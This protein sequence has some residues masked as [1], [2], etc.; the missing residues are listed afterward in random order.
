MELM[1]L[2]LARIL[3]VTLSAF[4]F[5]IVGAWATADQVSRVAYWVRRIQASMLVVGFVAIMAWA[6]Y[7]LIAGGP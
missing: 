1:D 7:S 2:E 4:A 5:I 3:L 6:A